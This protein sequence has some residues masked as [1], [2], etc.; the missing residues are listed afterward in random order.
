[1]TSR[2]EGNVLQVKIF[3]E[4]KNELTIDTTIK[5]TERTLER[6]KEIEAA[7]ERR[8]N[9]SPTKRNRNHM[10]KKSR[11]SN[12]KNMRTGIREYERFSGRDHN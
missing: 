8:C 3:E 5:S 9:L 2:R 7:S 1:M 4:G 11:K 12:R 6:E 10:G